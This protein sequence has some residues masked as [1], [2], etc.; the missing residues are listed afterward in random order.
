MTKKM[1]NWK[2]KNLLDSNENNIR[3]ARMY[4]SSLLH[5]P[6]LHLWQMEAHEAT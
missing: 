2:Y 6:I 3:N 4:L 5:F 1:Q